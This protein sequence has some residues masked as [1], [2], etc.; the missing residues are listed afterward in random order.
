MPILEVVPQSVAQVTCKTYIVE[1]IASVEGAHA[2]ASPNK[3]LHD[4]LVLFKG[5][6]GDP[7]EVLVNEGISLG[8]NL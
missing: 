3:L 2:L 6:P 8:H 4:V 1:F 7:F 5:L